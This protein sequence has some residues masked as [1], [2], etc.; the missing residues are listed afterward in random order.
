MPTATNRV[1]F[2]I[3]PLQPLVRVLEADD[4]L[5]QPV[6]PSFEYAKEFVPIPPAS[7]IFPF[8]VIEVPLVVNGLIFEAKF[9]VFHAIPSL[10]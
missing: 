3:R 2:Q 7:H 8:H 1:P 9:T 4:I 5:F 6:I 10:E